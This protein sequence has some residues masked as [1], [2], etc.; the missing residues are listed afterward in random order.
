MHVKSFVVCIVGKV[1]QDI[2]M[3]LKCCGVVPTL[4]GWFLRVPSIRPITRF[5]CWYIHII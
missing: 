1:A 5:S 3:V 4:F 2:G